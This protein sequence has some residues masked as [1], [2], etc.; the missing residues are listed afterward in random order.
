MRH[1][2]RISSITLRASRHR[3]FCVPNGC[4]LCSPIPHEYSTSTGARHSTAH[5]HDIRARRA[6]PQFPSKHAGKSCAPAFDTCTTPASWPHSPPSRECGQRAR[7]RKVQISNAGAQDLPAVW[8]KWFVSGIL[9][10]ETDS[11]TSAVTE[12]AGSIRASGPEN[13]T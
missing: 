1:E 5:L 12:H 13:A 6:L 8:P 4:W 11:V 3:P 10:S 9:G 2:T 7:R